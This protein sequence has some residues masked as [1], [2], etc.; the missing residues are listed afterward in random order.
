MG[1]PFQLVAA[2]RLGRPV[3]QKLRIWDGGI[4]FSA[5]VVFVYLFSF[6]VSSFSDFGSRPNF[7]FI[8]GEMIRQSRCCIRLPSSME[9]KAL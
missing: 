2:S 8:E 7:C 1:N 9:G 3:A 5:L 4:R 6:C